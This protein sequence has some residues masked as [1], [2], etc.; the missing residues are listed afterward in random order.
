MAEQK[1]QNKLYTSPKGVAVYPWI[2]RPD[3]KFKNEGEYSVRLR[4]PTDEAQELIKAINEKYVESQ[5]E[6]K[7]AN[8]KK[9]VKKAPLPYTDELD[10]NGEKTGNTLFKFTLKAKVTPKSGEPFTQ[11]PKIF[12]AKGK[13]CNPQIGGGSVL[14]VS[15]Q[16]VPYNA[17]I[18][19]GVTLRFNAVQVIELVAF[20]GG[21]DAGGYGFGAEDGYDAED[22]ED[23][24]MPTGGDSDGDF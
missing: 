8:P 16:I 19:A 1:A 2:N 23:P 20:I 18:G 21:K 15:F 24:E 6:A 4:V 11:S 7:K 14:K 22:V 13:L 12:D 9:T 3:T 10:D 17:P 5:A